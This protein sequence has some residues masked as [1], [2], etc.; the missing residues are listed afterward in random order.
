MAN[1]DK[2]PPYLGVC[3]IPLASLR[4]DFV[5]H[6]E[7]EESRALEKGLMTRETAFH[8]LKVPLSIFSPCPCVFVCIFNHVLAYLGLFA[9][10]DDDNIVV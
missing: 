4:F 7:L 3:G 6:L 10:D 2:L 1:F 8:V 5:W 9:N